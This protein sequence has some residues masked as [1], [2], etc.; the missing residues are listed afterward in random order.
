MLDMNPYLHFMGNAGEAMDF[1]KS[2]LGGTFLI[3]QRFKDTPGGDKMPAKDQEMFIH[4][5]LSIGNGNAILAS[6]K[7]HSMDHAL[8]AG[9]NVHIC[10]QA[11]SESETE[12]LFTQ[13][14][15]GGKIEMPLNKT[16]W[17]AYFG[18][19]QDRFGIHWMINYTYKQA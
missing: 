3:R 7:P 13:L 11:E 15:N 5:S 18:M 1:Y 8:T 9:D 4:I 2:V 12:R 6:D 19:C 16:F 14:S 17:G 10:I